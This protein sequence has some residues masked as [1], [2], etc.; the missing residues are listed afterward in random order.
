[1]SSLWPLG[2][3]IYV[4]GTIGEAFGANLQRRSLTDEA[5]RVAAAATP[6]EQQPKGKFQQRLWVIGFLLFV[7]AGI[8]MSGAL[9]FATQTVLAPL[10]LFLFVSNA[11]FA[12]WI[13]KENFAWFGW[14]GRALVFVVT[15][16]TMAVVAAPKHTEHYSNEEM[17]WLMRQAGFIVFCCFSGSFLIGV[18]YIKRRILASCQHD[19]RTIQRRWVRTVLNM[20]YG[21]IAGAFGGVNVTLTKTVFS[22]IVGEFNVG[23]MKAVLSS[24]ILWGTSFVLVGTY[25]LQIVVT[26]SGLEA[27]TAIIVLSAHS[28]TEEVM[29]TLGGILYFQDYLKF[30]VWSWIVFSLGNLMAIA[31]V[32]GLSHLRLRDMEAKEREASAITAESDTSEIDNIDNI[33]TVYDQKE[34]VILARK[35]S[36]SDSYL[37]LLDPNRLEKGTPT[38]SGSFFLGGEDQQNGPGRVSRSKSIQELKDC[39]L[40]MMAEIESTEPADDSHTGKSSDAD[41]LQIERIDSVSPTFGEPPVVMVKA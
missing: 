20:S 38:G 30:E 26:V 41:S 37:I 10:Q 2:I 14:D 3:A 15:G 24:P 21:A 35:R 12:T 31:S 19:P 16:V 27:T 6:E 32:I 11:F 13:N 7:F 39:E 29:A 18:W 33:E 28:V 34:G 40:G 5:S 4:A 1:M 22:L 8:S 9:F 23:G 17:V 25:V 36:V